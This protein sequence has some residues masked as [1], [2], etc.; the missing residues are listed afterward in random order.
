MRTLIYPIRK[1]IRYRLKRIGK[2]PICNGCAHRGLKIGSFVFPLCMRCSAIIAG[3]E[4]SSRLLVLWVGLVSNVLLLGAI[5]V[6][7][8][9]P[10][11][12]DWVV[13]EYWGIESTN[14]RRAYLGLLCGGGC[15]VTM[16]VIKHWT[17]T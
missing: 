8:I 6:A 2:V 13:Q 17:T 11:A 9:L 14:A 15:L 16:S 1:T 10:C 4:I 3:M 12:I 7:A 5:G